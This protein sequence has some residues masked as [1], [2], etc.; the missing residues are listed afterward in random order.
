MHWD[1]EGLDFRLWV[2][3]FGLDL[4]GAYLLGLRD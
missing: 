1:L 3:G 2:L 4:L